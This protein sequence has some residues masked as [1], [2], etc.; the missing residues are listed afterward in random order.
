MNPHSNSEKGFD[1]QRSAVI[2]Q[3]LIDAPKA[4]TPTNRHFR[5]LR[6][7]KV[8]I[9]TVALAL[10]LTGGTAVILSGPVTDKNQVK[11]FARAERNGDSF[12]GTVMTLT[13]GV[14]PGGEPAHD[15]RI[16]IDDALS[17]CSDLWAQ[18]AL[19][20]NTPNGAP[21]PGQHDPAFSHPVPRPLTVCVWDGAAAVIPGDSKVCAKLGLSEKSSY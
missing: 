1:D 14:K 6:V 13:A 7:A 19:D 11:C 3:M 21:G 8:V 20:A 10:A 18:H 12:P 17:A 16:A 4:G 5:K 2:R 15:S 9:P